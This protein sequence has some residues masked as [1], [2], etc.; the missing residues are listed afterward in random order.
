MTAGAAI[1]T[2][3]VTTTKPRVLAHSRTPY[4]VFY[5]VHDADFRVEASMPVGTTS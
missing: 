1:A 4:L 5:A 2:E 3:I